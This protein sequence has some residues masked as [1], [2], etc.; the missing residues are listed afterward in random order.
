TSCDP[1]A[2][3]TNLYAFVSG[4]PV[5]LVDPHGR[6]E[7]SA[8][9]MWNTTK[10]GISKANKAIHDTAGMAGQGYIDAGE[11]VIDSAGIE[12]ETAQDLIRGVAV[13]YAITASTGAEFVAGFAM[14][15]P[16]LLMLPETLTHVPEQLGGGASEIV[17]GIEES[18]ANRALIG[19]S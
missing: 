9:D 3:T 7:V 1:A 10:Q 14:L 4:D 16:N 13:S 18:N 11:L 12:N 5:D 15:G 17:Q 8:S 6:Q 2:S 19:A